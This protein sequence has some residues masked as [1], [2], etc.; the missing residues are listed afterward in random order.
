MSYVTPGTASVGINEIK[1]LVFNSDSEED[2]MLNDCD[3]ECTRDLAIC[4]VSVL[5][6]EAEKKRRQ[7][8]S[9]LFPIQV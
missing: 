6:N 8:C 9:I 4:V 7:G 5:R 1:V 2:F 3:F